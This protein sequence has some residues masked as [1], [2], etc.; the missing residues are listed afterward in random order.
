MI[1]FFPFQSKVAQPSPQPISSV[2]VATAL[3]PLPETWCAKTRLVVRM[4]RYENPSSGWRKARPVMGSVGDSWMVRPFG[5]AVREVDDV[6]D[7]SICLYRMTVPSPRPMGRWR[8]GIAVQRWRW[9]WPREP[10]NPR[11]HGGVARWNIRDEDGYQMD[12]K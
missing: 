5:R 11:V 10:F 4:N 8:G 6:S 1:I 2:S 7:C 9:W 12:F 3:A